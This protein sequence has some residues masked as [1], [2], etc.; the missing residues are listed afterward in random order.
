LMIRA[1]WENGM[2]FHNLSILSAYILLGLAAILGMP[3]ALAWPAFLTLPLGLFQ[4][5]AVNR[6]A[7]G[8]KP[9]WLNLSLMAVALLGLTTY[10]LAFGYWTR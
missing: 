7:A 10:L 3:I 5:R 4:I 2:L 1:G 8:N 6:I 9:N